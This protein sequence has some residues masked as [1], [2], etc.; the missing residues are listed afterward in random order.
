MSNRFDDRRDD[1]RR[2]RGHGGAA[3]ARYGGR[4]EDR[5]ISRRASE[6][7]YFEGE[8]RYGR[9][10]GGYVGPFGGYELQ[11][12]MGRETERD[13]W[14]RGRRERGYQSPGYRDRG[15]RDEEHRG[16]MERIGDTIASW[17]GDD[18]AARRTRFDEPRARGQHR[19]RGPKGY[20]RSD[21]RIREDVSDRL[22]DP[23]YLDAS[24]IEVTVAEAI[25]TLSGTVDDRASKRLAEDVAEEV[26]GVHDVNNQIRIN[27]PSYG[28]GQSASA[29]PTVKPPDKATQH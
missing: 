23:P 6:P 16:L 27:R 24:E 12:A 5:E 1:W 4:D 15:Y 10:L 25:V 19:G 17:F 20:R 14:D 3:R 9:D 18:E 26:S 11:S 13:A 21:E 7:D 8:R 2:E 29:T 28:A 22:A